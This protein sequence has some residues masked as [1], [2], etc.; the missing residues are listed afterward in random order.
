VS[1]KLCV[2]DKKIFYCLEKIKNFFYFSEVVEK[3][4]KSL[5]LTK[6]SKLFSVGSDE[7]KPANPI[8][9]RLRSEENLPTP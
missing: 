1:K 3:N 4:K 5:S 8:T 7:S 9:A 2:H 6:N